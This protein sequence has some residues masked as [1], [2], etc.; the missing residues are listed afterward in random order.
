ML[1]PNFSTKNGVRL[2]Y[3][4]AEFD[5]YVDNSAKTTVLSERQDWMLKAVEKIQEDAIVKTLYSANQIYAFNKN[6]TNVQM[7]CGGI[8]YMKEIKLA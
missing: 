8:I 2:K 1:E 4:N 7:D 5:E 6:F 3:N